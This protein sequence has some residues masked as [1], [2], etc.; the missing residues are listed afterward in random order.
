[1]LFLRHHAHHLQKERFLLHNPDFVIKFVKGNIAVGLY[2][3]VV[4]LVL[5]LQQ[6]L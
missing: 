4:Y 2:H 5:L 6:R 1:M 3:D